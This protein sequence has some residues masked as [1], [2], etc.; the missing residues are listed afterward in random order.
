M[1][2]LG[3]VQGEQPAREVRHRAAEPLLVAIHRLDGGRIRTRQ[4]RFGTLG[5]EPRALRRVER[6]RQTCLRRR[7][8]R[9]CFGRLERAVP[10]TYPAEE[11]HPVEE[12]H[13]EEPLVA[14]ADQLAEAHQVRVMEP[15][16]RPKLPL[17]SREPV[18]REIAQ[19]L[20]RD[21]RVALAIDRLVDDP[22]PALAEGSNDLEARRRGER[23][24]HPW[25]SPG[26][27]TACA[28]RRRARRSSSRLGGR[29]RFA[30]VQLVSS[31][32]YLAARRV[33]A[34][35]D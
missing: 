15:F 1:D 11:A 8:E 3:R 28:D 6:R 19:R 9:A 14:L 12:L 21:P 29:A 17:E 22:H 2:P 27:S 25:S 31:P 20:E 10:R 24:R 26:K 35:G 4:G 32:A 34:R 30:R 5:L 33:T 7:R 18:G 13:R 16:D 23:L